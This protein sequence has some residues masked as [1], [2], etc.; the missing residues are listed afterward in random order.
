MFTVCTVLLWAIKYSSV[1]PDYFSVAPQIKST[2][3]ST[4]HNDSIVQQMDN[5]VELAT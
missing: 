3:I 4:F 1:N 2:I 5:I